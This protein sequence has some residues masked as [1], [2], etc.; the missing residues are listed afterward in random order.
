LRILHLIE[1]ISAGGPARCLL[2]YVRLSRELDSDVEHRVVSLSA[3]GYPP[4]LYQYAAER[5]PL[6]RAPEP[7]RL[8]EAV[9]WA[10]VVLVHYWT[11]PRMLACLEQGWPDCRILL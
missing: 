8:A 1:E 9:T 3:G 5:I 6:E 11:T 7:A 2:G 10:D 4:V